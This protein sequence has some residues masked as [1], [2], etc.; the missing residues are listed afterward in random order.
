MS[1]AATRCLLAA[2]WQAF[3]QKMAARGGDQSDAVRRSAGLLEAP[4]KRF[5]EGPE[6]Q[7][8]YCPTDRA[9]KRRPSSALRECE[10]LSLWHRFQTLFISL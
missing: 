8:P 1:G 7:L 2:Q 10:C 3:G 9:N 4:R 6:V 5:A